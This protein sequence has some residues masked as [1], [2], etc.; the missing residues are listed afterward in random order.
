MSGIKYLIGIDEAGR[1]PIAGP[2]AVGVVMW[3]LDTKCPSL[4]PVS[5]SPLRDS[6]KLTARQREAWFSWLGEQKG[7]GELNW[8]VSLVAAGVIDSQGIVSAIRQGIDNCLK[9]VAAELAGFEPTQCQVLLDGSLRA[10]EVYINQK[11]IIKGDESEPI[12]SLAS[13]AAKVTRDKFMCKLGGEYPQ[14]GFERHKGYGTREHYRQVGAH[15]LCEAHRRSF[16]TV[17]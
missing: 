12:I 16:M 17:L 8:S 6:K 2:V 13:I 5:K 4:H 14:Y 15:G 11:T 1:G 7:A 10:P 9:Q 3:H